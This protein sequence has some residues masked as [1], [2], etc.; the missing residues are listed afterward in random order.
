[1]L[2]G[3][4]LHGGLPASWS[5]PRITAKIVVESLLEVLDSTIVNV[6]I[7]DIM[8]TFGIGQDRAQWISAAFMA[9]TT[10]SLLLTPWLLRS[11][12]EFTIG[13]IHRMPG[14]AH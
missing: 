3:I 9:A 12:T 1:M 11:L 8:G 2:N 4:S 5:E 14:L 7:P 6:A 10:L 13:I